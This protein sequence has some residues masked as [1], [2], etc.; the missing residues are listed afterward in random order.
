MAHGVHLSEVQ[1]KCRTCGQEWIKSFD[2]GSRDAR[3]SIVG[4]ANAIA[5]T[6]AAEHPDHDVPAPLYA[7][8]RHEWSDI[9]VTVD[10][11][12]VSP[13]SDLRFSIAKRLGGSR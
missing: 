3:D 13:V 4:E 6:H 1:V 11:F 9:E 8:D 10:G 7:V 12:S 2:A 5:R